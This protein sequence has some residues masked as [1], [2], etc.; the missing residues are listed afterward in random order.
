MDN[1]QQM[2]PLDLLL[3]IKMDT[4]IRI[5]LNYVS[6]LTSVLQQEAVINMVFNNWMEARIVLL[7]NYKFE[8][9]V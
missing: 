5:A 8:M 9:E 1:L 6:T 3:E 7:T 4:L 2:K